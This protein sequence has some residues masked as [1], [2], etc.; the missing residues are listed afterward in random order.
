MVFFNGTKTL[1]SWK[2]SDFAVKLE[3]HVRYF[4]AGCRR[5]LRAGEN[6]KQIDWYIHSMYYIHTCGLYI[7]NNRVRIYVTRR[8]CMKHT[9]VKTQKL[10]KWINWIATTQVHKFQLKITEEHIPTHAHLVNLNSNKTRSNQLLIKLSG[11]T[12]EY[13]IVWFPFI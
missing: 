2:S 3:V 13:R 12:V 7:H 11:F 8:D 4:D 1:Q 5:K 10:F 6:E 9:E